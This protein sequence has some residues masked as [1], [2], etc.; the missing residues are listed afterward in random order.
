MQRCPITGRR[1]LASDVAVAVWIFV[2]VRIGFWI[3]DLVAK[4][5]GPGKTVQE[6]GDG[7]ARNLES[8]RDR[9]AISHW[10]ATGSR[11]RSTRRRGP[12]EP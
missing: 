10:S 8:I 12:G 3:D 1:Q 5:A 7:F 11:H 4:L 2:W 9:S 6:A